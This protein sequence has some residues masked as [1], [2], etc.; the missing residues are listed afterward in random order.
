MGQLTK[1]DLAD[2][3][4]ISV[5]AGNGGINL[6]SIDGPKESA[7]FNSATQCTI[8]QDGTV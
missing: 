1:I 6:T 3:N 8:D 5:F 2:N 7:I 4:K